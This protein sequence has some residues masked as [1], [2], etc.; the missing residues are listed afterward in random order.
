MCNSVL[1]PTLPML[2]TKHDTKEKR[3]RNAAHHTYEGI[4]RATRGTNLKSLLGSSLGAGERRP[5][6]LSP[7]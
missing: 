5:R 7:P 3:E 2:S 1:R 4:G 6:K